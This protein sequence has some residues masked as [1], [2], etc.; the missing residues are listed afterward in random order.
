SPATVVLMG[1]AAAPARV[2]VGSGT[3]LARESAIALDEY[4][5]T[6][7]DVAAAF[8]RYE[9]ERRTEVLRLQSA[10]RNSTEWFENIERYLHLDPVQFNY[11]LLT[12]S[13]RIS[14]E[15][16]RV[17]D[18]AWL[19]GAEAWFQRRADSNNPNARRPMFAPFR[20]RDLTLQ[21]HIVV[22]PQ[23]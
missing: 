13:Q 10:A 11:S 5:H 3:T 12:R 19:E 8:H 23:A 16:L 7:P 4:L 14:H 15:N 17:R 1:D 20:L 2:S 9:E 6:E 21:N 22:S 18:K